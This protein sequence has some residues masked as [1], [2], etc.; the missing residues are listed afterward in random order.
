MPAAA[1]VGDAAV[2]MHP[3]TAHGFNL[4]LLGQDTLARLVRAAMR[5]GDDPGGS[6]LLDRYERAHRRATW[7]PYQATGAIVRLYGE[8]A[9]PARVLRD[10]GLRIGNTLPLLRRTLMTRMMEA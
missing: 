1:R 7:L 5:R 8:T 2:G 9:L 6:V 3:V 10:A 4:G